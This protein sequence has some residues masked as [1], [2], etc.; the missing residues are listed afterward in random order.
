MRIITPGVADKKL[1]KLMTKSF[2]LQLVTCG[3][4]IFEYTPG[5]IHEKI[6]ICDDSSA[7]VGTVNLDYRSLV[8]HFENALWI[9]GSPEII[10]MRESFL[11]TCTLCHEISEAEAKLR[12]HERILRALT[13]LF[14]PLL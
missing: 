10:K 6:M 2:Y 7:I 14:A 4:R 5:F 13:R 9:F 8:H 12:L 3:V 11:D 1:V